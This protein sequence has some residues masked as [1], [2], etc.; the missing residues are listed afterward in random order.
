MEETQKKG[1]GV[2]WALLVVLV[3]VIT[4]GVVKLGDKKVDSP[5]N[6]DTEGTEEATATQ[7]TEYMYKDGTYTAMGS[8]TSPAGPEEI[9]VSLTLKDGLVTNTVVVPKAT[10]E[11][12]IKLQGMFIGGLQ[13]VVI[14]KSIDD[15]E[16]DKV[17][18]SSLTPKGWN[19]A[20]AKIQAQARI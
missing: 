4:F 15:V 1:K 14:G 6:S 5:V 2:W 10:N 8:Y 19:D 7:T 17:A 20:V 18:G 16:L 13:S 9:E 3:A 12:S 11:V